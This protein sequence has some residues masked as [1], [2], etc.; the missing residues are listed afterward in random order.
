MDTVKKVTDDVR[1]GGRDESK[2]LGAARAGSDDL[3]IG[4][5]AKDEAQSHRV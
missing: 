4:L 1:S 2:R 5:V 3:D